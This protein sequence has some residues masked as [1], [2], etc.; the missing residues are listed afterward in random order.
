MKTL[1]TCLFLG[2]LSTAAVADSYKIGDLV[3]EAP[4]S[5]STP[6][7]APVGGGYMTIINNGTEADTLVSGES[8]FS[9][10]I[11]IHQ[12]SMKDGIMKMAELKGG[13]EIP[14]GETVVLDPGSYH[15]MF[16]TL[17]EQLKPDER[18]KATLKFEKAGEVDVEFLVK[19]ILKMDHSRMKHDNMD[20]GKMDHSKMKHSD[21]KKAEDAKPKM[22][23]SKMEAAKTE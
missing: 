20:H 10:S 8:S 4:Y 15:L 14:A 22:D 16:V 7:F 6:P 17:A 5:R 18:R 2:L 3:I 19:D 12:M 21:I 9:K 13:L 1:L 11:E 23:H